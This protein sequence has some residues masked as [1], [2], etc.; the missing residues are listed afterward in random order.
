MASS[1]HHPPQAETCCPL[2]GPAHPG[3]QHQL[4]H[5]HKAGEVPLRRA[6][7]SPG[8]NLRG[9]TGREEPLAFWASSCFSKLTNPKPLERPLLSVMTLTLKVFPAGGKGRTVRGVPPVLGATSRDQP[10]EE[11]GQPW[12][13]GGAQHEDNNRIPTRWG[14]QAVKFGHCPGL[15]SLSSQCSEFLW[16]EDLIFTHEHTDWAQ[17]TWDDADQAWT[18]WPMGWH[19]T[20]AHYKRHPPVVH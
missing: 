18:V 10:S 13:H 11:T 2:P 8:D 14:Q 5:R 15:L 1:A 4:P 16:L 12:Q 3:T 17:T 6:G 20:K 19:N 9:E 7:T